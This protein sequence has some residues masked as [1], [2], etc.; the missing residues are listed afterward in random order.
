MC[1]LEDGVIAD[2]GLHTH[3]ITSSEHENKVVISGT[4]EPVA[5]ETPTKVLLVGA[6]AGDPTAT[7]IQTDHRFTLSRTTPSG[8]TETRVMNNVVKLRIQAGFQV[9]ESD[10]GAPCLVQVPGTEN[11]YKMCC[12]LF[13]KESASIGLAMPASA[14]EQELGIRFGENRPPVANAGPDQLMAPGARVTLDGSESSDP[15]GDTLTYLWEQLPGVGGSDVT[16]SDTSAVSPTFAAPT[17][18]AALSFQ[19]TVTDSSGA[20]HTDTVSVTVRAGA[21]SLGG[22]A[23]GQTYNRT[24]SWSSEVPSV[25]RSGRY[26]KFYGFSLS[27]RGKVR[28]DLSSSVDPYLYLLSGAG[29]SGS[30]LASDDDSGGSGNSRI[31]REL[32]AGAYTL[33][34][35]TYAARQVGSCTLAVQVFSNDATLSGLSLSPASASLTPAFAPDEESYTASVGNAVSSVRVTPTVNE[36]NATVTVK[37]TAVAS[38]QQ[39]GPIS[40]SVG[41]N[42][43]TVVVTAEDGT[44]K[45]YTVDVTRAAA[46][47]PTPTSTPDPTP[48]AQPVN[49]WVATG[50]T[51]GC[52]PTY[53]YEESF[54]SGSGALYFRWV[55]DPQTETWVRGRTRGTRCPLVV[56]TG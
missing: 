18:P 38:G 28:I 20:S 33:E 36:A 15:D 46:P 21:E 1:T 45:T 39:S 23:H 44:T 2:F 27:Q 31:D 55:S 26:A 41:E 50:N 22:L 5:G 17:G 30:V 29:T 47:A 19:L 52:G 8:S 10:S 35:T 43:I 7:V 11:Q 14:L 12:V 37:G 34:A 16:L 32:E 24:G 51:R 40:L 42:T 13:A 53:E 48:P 9:Q 4:V 56:D 6:R 25:N 3:P 49:T 54:Y